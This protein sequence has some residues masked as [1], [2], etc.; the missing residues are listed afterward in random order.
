MSQLPVPPAFVALFLAFVA[1]TGCPGVLNDIP[2]DCDNEI[3]DDGDED[4]DCRDPDC[5][6]E[7]AG[8]EGEGEGDP[9]PDDNTCDGYADH[10][11]TCGLSASNAEAIRQQCDTLSQDE[12]EAIIACNTSESCSEFRSCSGVECFQDVDCP[13]ARP[14]CIDPADV[15]DPFTDIPFT[16]R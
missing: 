9:P 15:V 7:C 10:A 2:E 13:A 3:D 12:Q 1:A 14:D 16:C 5:S 8:G 4:I 6:T 11:E